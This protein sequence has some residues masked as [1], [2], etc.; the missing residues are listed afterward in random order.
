M[1]QLWCQACRNH[2]RSITGIKNFSRSWIVGSTNQKTSNL[3]DHAKS[4]QHRAAMSRMYAESAKA[5]KLPVTSYSP[6]ARSLLTIDEGTQ[7]RL[8]KKFD[9]CYVVAKQGLSFRKY[10]SIHALQE[11]HDVN[12]GFSYKTV[13][14]FRQ[15][16][17]L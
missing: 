1:A 13:D 7:E 2:E 11:R 6:I 3:V 14:S 17:T 15:Q 10:P 16:V 9:I 5:S 8:R 4:E 12:L